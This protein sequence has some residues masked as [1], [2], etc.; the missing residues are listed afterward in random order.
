[1]V[2][3][4]HARR[5]GGYLKLYPGK[6]RFRLLY[7]RIPPTKAISRDFPPKIGPATG[8]FLT[9]PTTPPFSSFTAHKLGPVS[10]KQTLQ[11]IG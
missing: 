6:L 4:R 7:T 3:I 8:C 10:Q 2:Q 11:R 1:M 9:D 5:R